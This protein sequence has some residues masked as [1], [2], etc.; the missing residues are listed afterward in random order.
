MR[1]RK[2]EGRTDAFPRKEGQID[3]LPS[4][5]ENVCIEANSYYMLFDSGS[6]QNTQNGTASNQ[7]TEGGRGGK[8]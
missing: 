4:R 2:L 8:H 5:T 1:F 6:Y 7:L 3:A